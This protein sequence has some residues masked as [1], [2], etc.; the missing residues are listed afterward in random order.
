M[1]SKK[2][3]VLLAKLSFVIVRPIDYQIGEASLL[4]NTVNF[5]L[6]FPNIWMSGIKIIANGR[7]S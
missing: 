5:W 3:D 6:S 1:T 7:W 2:I 4:P